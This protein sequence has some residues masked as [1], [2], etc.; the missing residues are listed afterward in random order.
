[1]DGSATTNFSRLQRWYSYLN[2]RIFSGG[3]LEPGTYRAL[4]MTR[5]AIN[6]AMQRI[7]NKVGKVP[8]PAHPE[9]NTT[10]TKL[11]ER[12]R[13]FH[14]QRM[15][16]FGDSPNEP[17]TNASEVLKKAAPEYVKDTKRA[18]Q[19]AMLSR[20][21]PAISTL[22]DYLD[23][24]TEGV[25]NL[26]T[27]KPLRER[28]KE[29]PKP[30]KPEAPP[31][32]PSVDHPSTKY[33]LKKEPEA[34]PPGR[35]TVRQPER[36]TH[37]NRPPEVVPERKEISPEQ[38]QEQRKTAVAKASEQLRQLGVRR[39]L[40]ALFYTMPTAV[41][42]TLLGHPGYAYTEAAMA[43]MILAG[44]H[45]LAG[46]LEQPGVVEWISKVTPRDVAAY[47]KLPPEEKAVFTQNLRDLVDQAHTRGAIVSPAL[48]AF[49]GAAAASAPRAPKSLKELRDE[50]AKRK[51]SAPLPAPGP[52]SVQSLIRTSSMRRGE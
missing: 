13:K 19:V 49:L 43:P 44:S 45:A 2:N 48:T 8:D 11:L 17:A 51:A 20:F 21:D 50:A 27:D 22:N 6:E 46:L 16:A 28:W 33:R 32:P 18:K 24:L 5:D 40:N 37:P 4:M 31:E 41:L 23:G 26:S 47:E 42:S 1:M 14:Q 34:P 12:A 3:R 36:A 35:E 7:T 38:L 30:P 9:Q 29:P 52:Q 15:E 25:K 10:A 39:A